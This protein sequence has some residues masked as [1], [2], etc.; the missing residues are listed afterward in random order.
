L[1]VIDHIIVGN[2]F[3]IPDNPKIISKI[4]EREIFYNLTGIERM[5]RTHKLLNLRNDNSNKILEEW[6]MQKFKNISD[7][8]PISAGID[9]L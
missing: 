1:Q 2:L 8:K 5:L 6:K 4:K 9:I 7:H 3:S